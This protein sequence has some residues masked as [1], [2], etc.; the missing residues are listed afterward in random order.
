MR[1]GYL[2]NGWIY[3]EKIVLE[4]TIIKKGYPLKRQTARKEIPIK[5][6]ALGLI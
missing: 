6:K 1:D 4:T 3:V 2:H 5:Q